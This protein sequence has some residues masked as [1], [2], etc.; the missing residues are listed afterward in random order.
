MTKLESMI[1]KIEMNFK[2]LKF[3]LEQIELNSQF[4]DPVIS[5]ESGKKSNNFF[6]TKGK[7]LWLGRR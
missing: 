3:M 1:P 6:Q 5:V 7:S 2:I 4:P